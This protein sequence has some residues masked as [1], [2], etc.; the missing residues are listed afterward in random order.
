MRA[1]ARAG[2]L[3]EPSV[4]PQAGSLGEAKSIPLSSARLKPGV[5]CPASFQVNGQAKA[6][7]GV[8]LKPSVKPQAGSLGEAKS[9]PQSSP[10][11]EAWEKRSPSL[12]QAPG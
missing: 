11:Q 9:I 6:R 2:I 4:K 3:F 10:R 7:A 5:S 12:C 1:K 8:L